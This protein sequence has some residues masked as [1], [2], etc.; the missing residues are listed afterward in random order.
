MVN[1]MCNIYREKKRSKRKKKKKVGRV[2]NFQQS[3]DCFGGRGGG[4]N[5]HVTVGKREK[6][7]RGER[8]ARHAHPRW[9][10][11][12]CPHFRPAHNGLIRLVRIGPN[13]VRSCWAHQ[14]RLPWS[15]KPA[16][17]QSQARP[18]PL[19]DQWA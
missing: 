18:G 16:K 14:A 4:S 3:C 9:T 11:L 8:W 1:K 10:N 15:V 12:A 13:Q 7:G 2:P 6:G 5:G 19:T 17:F